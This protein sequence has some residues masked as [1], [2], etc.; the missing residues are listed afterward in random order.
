MWPKVPK[1]KVATAAAKNLK[2]HAVEILSPRTACPAVEAVK[3]R[4][5]LSAE[6][7]LLPLFECTRSGICACVYRKF[8]DRRAGARREHEETGI[9]R[10]AMPPQERRRKRGRRKAD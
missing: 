4:R 3:G 1:Q 8:A 10:T 7:P 5:F 9:R 2:W 6:A